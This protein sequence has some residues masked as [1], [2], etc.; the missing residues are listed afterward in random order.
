MAVVAGMFRVLEGRVVFVEP[1]PSALA[2]GDR[3]P[4]RQ[5]HDLRPLHRCATVRPSFSW[6]AKVLAGAARTRVT[7][8]GDLDLLFARWQ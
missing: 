6:L 3:A 8:A 4:L 2:V 5:S 1:S 7:S